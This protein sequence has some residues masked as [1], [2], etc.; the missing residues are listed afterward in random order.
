MILCSVHLHK[1]HVKVYEKSLKIPKCY[2]QS[3]I[4]DEQTTQIPKNKGY[5]QINN[6][7]HKP[8]QKIKDYETITQHT[9]WG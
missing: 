9:F 1:M 5:K 2:K 7:P 3:E 6:G 4:D 8:T